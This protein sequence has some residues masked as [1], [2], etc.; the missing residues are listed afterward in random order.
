VVSAIRDEDK[1]PLVLLLLEIIE[2]Q[3]QY[4]EQ[5]AQRIAVLEAEIGR[6]KGPRKP[7]SNSKPSALSKPAAAPSPDG[8]RP[9]SEKRAKTKDLPIHEEIPLPPKDLPPGALESVFGWPGHRQRQ[10]SPDADGGGPAGQRD[11][12]WCV[13]GV[14]HC[15]RRLSNLRSVR[16]WAVL[17]SPGTQPG[18][19]DLVR[20][21][22][23][24]TNFSRSF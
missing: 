2:Q 11:R 18:E 12:P 4:I 17:D 1:T 6:L 10:A 24:A 9:G 20:Q 15:Q 16:S 13:A 21:R 3:A 7:T 23:V 8:K 14:G 19:T 22:A 5:Q